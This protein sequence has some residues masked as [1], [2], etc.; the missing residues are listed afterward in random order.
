MF[1][2]SSSFFAVIISLFGFILLGGGLLGLLIG[3]PYLYRQT[4]SSKNWRRYKWIVPISIFSICAGGAIL[5][6]A[7]WE[8]DIIKTAVFFIPILLSIYVYRLYTVQSKRQM[9]QLEAMIAEH[10]AELTENNRELKELHQTKDSFL[11]VLT[12]DMRTS[13][14]NIKG[15]AAVLSRGSLLPEQQIHISQVLMRSQDSLMKIVNNI[16]EIEKLES[17]TPIQLKRSDFDLAY[18]VMLTAENALPLAKE[19]RLHLQFD[20]NPATLMVNGDREK[21][22]RVLLNLLSNAI[23][24]TEEGGKVAIIARRNGEYAAVDVSDTGYGV[25]AGELPYI[26]DRYRRVKGHQHIAIGTGLGLAVVKSLVTAHGGEIIVVS[27]EN[28][29]SIFTISLPLQ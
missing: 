2:A 20:E 27:E 26:F 8:I 3:V 19:K 10:T 13:L 1:S 4:P 5:A 6:F 9:E 16:L 28:M 7:I 29:G 18:L 23:K 12:H 17:G 21:I 22:K 25:P 11:A 24:Y 15:Y 14:S